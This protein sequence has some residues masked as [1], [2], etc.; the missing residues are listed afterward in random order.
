MGKERKIV[1]VVKKFTF[2][3]AEAADV[4]KLEKRNKKNK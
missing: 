1:A 4:D 3:E 2:E